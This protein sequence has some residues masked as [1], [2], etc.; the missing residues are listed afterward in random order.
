MKNPRISAENTALLANLIEVGVKALQK[1]GTSTIIAKR[2][3][4]PYTDATLAKLVG[5]GIINNLEKRGGAK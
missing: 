1:S 2:D 5:E 3:G 4:V